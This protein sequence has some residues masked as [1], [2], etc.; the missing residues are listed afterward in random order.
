MP[1]QIELFKAYVPILDEVY[2]VS[3]LTSQ[4]D[5]NP[6]L[7]REGANANEL[8]IPMLDMQG[9]ADYSRNSGY[10]DGDVTLTNE[11]VPVNF[12][13]GRM[14]SVDAMDNMETANLAFGRLAG[15]FIRTKV[16]PE[17]DAFRLAVYAGTPGIG[18]ATGDL[19]T[20][21]AV[22][23]ALRNATNALDEAE[24][25]YDERLL[26]VTPTLIGMVDDLDTDK[27]RAVL[28]R[29]SAAVRVPQTRFYT[30][31]DQRDGF[32][33]GQEAGGYVKA[34]D[35]KN[36]NFMVLH[37]PALIQFTKHIAPKI[38]TPDQN[39]RADAWKYGYRMVSVTDVYTN[40]LAG[41]YMHK[42]TA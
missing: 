40:K 23:A 1:N 12:D 24:V 3:S 10:V 5:G 14:F 41:V 11:T 2:K 13:R 34:A 37:R 19:T 25:P 29:F 21:A 42:A 35:A 15:E 31:I 18:V 20:G 28:A 36:I 17:L 27:S 7:A 32:T 9:L 22:I 8:I 30:A 4:L 39:Q 6:D 33:A 38:V 16:V 26:Y